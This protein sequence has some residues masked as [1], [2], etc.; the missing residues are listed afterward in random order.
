M[1]LN[2]ALLL[3]SLATWAQTG[4]TLSQPFQGRC[5]QMFGRYGHVQQ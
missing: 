3:L 1:A 5:P 2:L 4:E